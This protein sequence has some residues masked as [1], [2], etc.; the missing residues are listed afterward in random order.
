[1]P[2]TYGQ[3]T[4]DDLKK[5]YAYLKTVPRKGEKTKNQLAAAGSG[6]NAT[7]S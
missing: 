1:M 6:P 5:I 2:R 7:G 3:M 4:D